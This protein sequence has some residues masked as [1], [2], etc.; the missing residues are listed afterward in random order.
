MNHINKIIAVDAFT[1]L[2]DWRNGEKRQLDFKEIF[3]DANGIY[4]QLLMPEIFSTVQ[5]NGRSLY[6]PNLATVIDEKGEKIISDL[7]FCADMIY[8]NSKIVKG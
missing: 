7:D 2:L 1:I 6:W 4:K 5:T 3:Q 8:K